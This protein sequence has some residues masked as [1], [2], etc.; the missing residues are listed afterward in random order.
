M[1]GLNM[2]IRLIIVVFGLY[3]VLMSPMAKAAET[4][5][6]FDISVNSCASVTA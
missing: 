3:T 6:T 1:I 5:I 2:R 4:V